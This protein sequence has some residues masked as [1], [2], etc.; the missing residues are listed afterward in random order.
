MRKSE[1][2]NNLP[3]HILE[4]I[5]SIKPGKRV[6]FR[7]LNAKLDPV[8]GEMDFPTK[9]IP[10]RA[11]IYDERTNRAYDIAYITG[12]RT[13]EQSGLTEEVVDQIWFSGSNA[14]QIVL[15]MN[16]MGHRDL[17]EY[18][19]LHPW[20]ESNPN[21]PAGADKVY[22]WVEDPK[23]YEKDVKKK[24]EESRLMMKAS[25]LSEQDLR[26]MA[27]YFSGLDPDDDVIRLRHAAFRMAEFNPK[28]FS[29]ALDSIMVYGEE[30][31]LV[32]GALSNDIIYFDT[33]FGHNKWRWRG[34]DELIFNGMKGKSKS[35]NEKHF[36]E[37]LK[38]D[39]KGRAI[40]AQL[41]DLLTPVEDE[42]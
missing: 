18:L 26:K 9:N 37:W 42:A 36:A 40:A 11:T 20:N 31:D 5:P 2:Y 28:R 10:P 4:T 17:F 15:D 23:R 21:R 8:S 19:W 33:R 16:V 38:N 41:K 29:I 22:C 1:R 34:T 32:V 27:V 39:K 35:D 25:Q 3:D 30:I 24:T 6:T 14:C 7:L 12:F 13:N